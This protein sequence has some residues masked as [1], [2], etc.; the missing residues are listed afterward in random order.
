[1]PEPQ[2]EEY[3]RKVVVE[4]VSSS[5]SSRNVMGTIIA[6]VVIAIALVVFIFSKMN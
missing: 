3:A 6:I 1:M 4:Q 5:G 2:D